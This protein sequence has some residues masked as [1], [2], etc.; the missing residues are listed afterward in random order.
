MSGA[1][2]NAI[3]DSIMGGL[4]RLKFSFFPAHLRHM[5]A[6]RRSD[7]HCRADRQC[8]EQAGRI[9]PRRHLCRVR[10][11]AFSVNTSYLKYG[12]MISSPPS[13]VLIFRAGRYGA[14][15]L[16]RVPMDVEKVRCACSIV[17]KKSAEQPLRRW[18]MTVY[19][20]QR[21][22]RQKKAVAFLG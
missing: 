19:L 9:H 8:L 1:S 7:P 14:R 18:K 4:D 11:K 3:T 21:L 13:N 17:C 20:I 5:S 22:I 12:C 16:Y 10:G 6:T 2:E 15:D